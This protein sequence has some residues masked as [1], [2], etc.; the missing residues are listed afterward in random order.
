MR[1]PPMSIP[2]V[3]A[4]CTGDVPASGH[5]AD[6]GM[7]GARAVVVGT[8]ASGLNLRTRP[9]TGSESLA[10][11]PEGCLVEVIGGPD[12][13]WYQ[14]SWSKETGWVHGDFLATASADAPDLC[15]SGGL[16]YYLP[17]QAGDAHR[18]TNGHHTSTHT[19]KDAWAWDFSF[20]VG[21]PVLATHDGTIRRVKK[22][23]TRGGCNSA[24]ANDA[25]YVVIS[26][27]DGLETLYMHLETV[28]VD[29]GQTVVRGTFLGKSGQSGWACGPHL[30]YQ[31][32][33]GPRGG[34]TES[35]WN[36]SVHEFFHDTGE[37]LDPP[38]DT[39]PVSANVRR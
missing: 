11:I 9:S 27:S 29:A 8:D 1:L 10:L 23:S 19:G 35:W 5:A 2:L 14:V 24:F 4:A 6:A 17:W 21:T 31:V 7:I 32:Q 22:D 20:A 13:A 34:G 18:V 28:A 30:H 36:Q 39:S 16:A 25:N 33:K 12:D 15:S 3:L 38:E 37:P 26:R